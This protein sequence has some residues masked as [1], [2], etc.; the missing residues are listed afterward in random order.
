MI[1][2]DLIELITKEGFLIHENDIAW[3]GVHQ[4]VLDLVPVEL[5]YCYFR[6]ETFKMYGGLKLRLSKWATKKETAKEMWGNIAFNISKRTIDKKM[7]NWKKDRKKAM[8]KRKPKLLIFPAS[9]A[10]W[11]P[12]APTHGLP[13]PSE[14]K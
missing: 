13:V 4:E 11:Q 3:V 6:D 1:I 12:P 5:E 7:F 10:A 2:D 14:K 8:P 9:D